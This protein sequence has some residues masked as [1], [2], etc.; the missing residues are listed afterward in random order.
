MYIC[1]NQY[2]NFNGIKNSINR[3]LISLCIEYKLNKKMKFACLSL[4][5]LLGLASCGEVIQLNPKPTDASPVVSR[6]PSFNLD[7]MKNLRN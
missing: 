1:R 3:N 5:S 2:S 7:V 6:I 4:L